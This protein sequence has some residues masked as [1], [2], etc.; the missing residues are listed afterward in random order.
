MKDYLEFVKRM[1]FK[2]AICIERTKYFCE[3]KVSAR[4]EQLDTIDN[5]LTKLNVEKD[6][7]NNMKI[8]NPFANT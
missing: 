2:A 8:S 1:I 6:A 5:Y 4:D 7:D 3:G